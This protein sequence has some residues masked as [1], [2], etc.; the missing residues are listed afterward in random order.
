M[1]ILQAIVASAV[2]T[3]D[4]RQGF[5][6]VCC[7]NALPKELRQ[8]AS[9]IGYSRD[10]GGLP[11]FSLKI[12]E[13]AGELWILMNRTVPAVD[14]TGR[15]SYLSHSLALE[16]RSLNDFFPAGSPVTS[17]F[18]FMRHYA[19]LSSWEGSPK[20][21]EPTEDIDVAELRACNYG[22]SKEGE[23][24]DP[25]LLLAFDYRE[26]PPKPRRAVWQLAGT[27]PDNMLELFHQTWFCIDPWCGTKKYSSYLPEPALS[28][29]DSWKCSFTTNLG[30]RQSDAH[31]WIVASPSCE[32]IPNRDV[33]D[34]TQWQSETP[35]SIKV[36]IGLDYGAL[37]V[38]RCTQSP[39]VWA[40]N[41][42]RAMLAEI[43]FE[44]SEKIKE[45]NSTLYADANDILNAISAE[46][47]AANEYITEAEKIQWWIFD[48]EANVMEWRNTLTN[49]ERKACN[50][51]QD[52]FFNF[53]E[54]LKPILLLLGVKDDVTE[55]LQENVKPIFL[56]SEFDRFNRLA[57]EFN[58]NGKIVTLLKKSYGLH[59]EAEKLKGDLIASNA[60]VKTAELEKKQL[61][62]KWTESQ[63]NVNKLGKDINLLS[64]EN[65]TYKKIIELNN[66]NARKRPKWQSGKGIAIISTTA[67]VLLL[68]AYFTIHYLTP[69]D[70]TAGQSPKETNNGTWNESDKSAA[71]ISNLETDNKRLQMKIDSLEADIIRLK[72]V[73]S[74]DKPPL[75]DAKKPKEE[76]AGGDLKTTDN[77]NPKEE[78]A[79]KETKPSVD[80]LKNQTNPPVQVK[81]EISPE[82]ST[83]DGQKSPPEQKEKPAPEA[84]N[85]D[86]K[87]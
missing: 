50:D 9:D 54:K 72:K 2:E 59:H 61:H 36:K 19:W 62:E 57:E 48:K 66:A 82:P 47:D 78:D 87:Q 53:Q 11:I 68:L 45:S 6:L 22:A 83:T 40:E 27:N 30:S 52:E 25:S 44:F 21:L 4:G 69:S 1:K 42:L 28:M 58:N 7:S 39:R 35:E 77:K 8:E 64:S 33:I 31:Q 41:G 13:A 56:I 37:L 10:A 70:K 16:E 34:P 3:L 55:D 79:S 14:F 15:A 26:E 43:R 32:F 60:L 24:L 38:D 74:F 80:N 46:R 85:P 81:P 49:L 51:N 76:K 20:L 65:A 23:A 17:V 12:I 18:E 71:K 73:E 84:K 29:R 75:P 63:N 5:G 86:K 67:A